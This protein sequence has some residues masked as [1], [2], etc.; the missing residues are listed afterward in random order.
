ML[1]SLIIIYLKGMRRMMFQLSGF[2]YTAKPRLFHA[3]LCECGGLFGKLR[4]EQLSAGLSAPGS[5]EY[6]GLNT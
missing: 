6:R 2:Y 1:G 5:D 3:L 4:G